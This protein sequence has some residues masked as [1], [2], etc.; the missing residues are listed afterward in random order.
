M[1]TNINILLTELGD[2]QDELNFNALN[3]FTYSYS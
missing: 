2:P 3:L 1:F